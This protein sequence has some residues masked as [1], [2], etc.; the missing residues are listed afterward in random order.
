[1]EHWSTN[2]Q[3]VLSNNENQTISQTVEIRKKNII[4]L[5]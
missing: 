4:K 3:D 5:N 1:M 2:E